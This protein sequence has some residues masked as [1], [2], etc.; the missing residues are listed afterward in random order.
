LKVQNKWRR[1]HSL[2]NNNN[3]LAL[4]EFTREWLSNLQ[5]MKA[6][7]RTAAQAQHSLAKEEEEIYSSSIFLEGLVGV[8]PCH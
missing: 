5:A 2:L 7:M 4:Q 1:C 3:N 6:Q 8:L